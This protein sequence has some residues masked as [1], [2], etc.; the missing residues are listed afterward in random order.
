MRARGALV[1]LLTLAGVV[2]APAAGLRAEV[3]IL[4]STHQGADFIVGIP[5]RDLWN[6]DLVIFA[7]DYEGEGSGR[8]SVTIPPL[9]GQ[10]TKRGYAWAA[11]GYRSKGYHPD[12][13]MADTLALR[14][15]FVNEIGRPKRTIIH[16][17]SMGGYVAIASLEIHPEIYQG[18]L[19]E[20][21]AVNGVGLVDWLYAYG[22]A[23]DYLSGVRLLDAPNRTVFDTLVAGPWGAAMGMP[24]SYTERGRRFDSVVKHLMGGDLPLRLEGLKQRY[25]TKLDVRDPWPHGAQELARNASTKDIRYDIDAGLGVDAAT[26]NRDIQRVTPA[27]GARSHAHNAV[28]AELTGKIRVPVMT[29]HETGDLHVP[30]RME[31]DYRRRTI[32]ADTGR[33]LVQRA[34]RGPGHCAFNTMV[35]VRAFDD[36]TEW[37]ARGVVPEGD[38]VLA[39]D[40]SKLGLRWTPV[41]HPADPVRP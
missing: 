39:A 4:Q 35:R 6:G 19:I 2:A 3:S 11:S 40:V 33:F 26:L 25:L 22:A 41:R 38:D 23:A 1:A 21:G 13:F 20:C 12:L 14:E 24:G 16:G 8:G 17:Q 10:L 34:V 31:Q 37:I 7:H 32:A 28:F 15:R 29:I 27:A 30:F 9:A 5:R 18:A 36:L